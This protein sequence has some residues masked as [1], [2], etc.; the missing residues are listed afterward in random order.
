MTSITTVTLS[1][2]VVQLTY[3][4]FAKKGCITFAFIR[5]GSKSEGYSADIVTTIVSQCSGLPVALPTMLYFLCCQAAGMQWA[6]DR[7]SS[8]SG[9]RIAAC[10]CMDGWNTLWGRVSDI[11]KAWSHLGNAATQGAWLHSAYCSVTSD[12]I[13]HRLSSLGF[14][15][16]WVFVRLVSFNPSEA[17]WS[18]LFRC[19]TDE[20]IIPTCIACTLHRGAHKKKAVCRNTW[21]LSNW[22]VPR[23]VGKPVTH[24]KIKATQ[25]YRP[26]FSEVLA[27]PLFVRIWQTCLSS[28]REAEWHRADFFVLSFFISLRL[29][30]LPSSGGLR[31][32]SCAPLCK[33][34]DRSN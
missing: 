31:W 17:A 30:S 14:N 23:A 29:L 33:L 24:R 5:R 4:I 34:P 11:L 7:S 16:L 8:R 28:T 20:N 9:L 21:K 3:L 22:V 32:K 27:C 2:S 18:Q 1:A 13:A 26:P 12:W 15:L 10:E 6:M 19:H 25:P